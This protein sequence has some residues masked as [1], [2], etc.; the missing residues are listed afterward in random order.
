VSANLT[1]STG[2]SSTSFVNLLLALLLERI[3]LLGTLD[4]LWQ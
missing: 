4:A 1:E 2:V 3:K